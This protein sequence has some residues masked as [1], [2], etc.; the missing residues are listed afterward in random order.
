MATKSKTTEVTEVETVVAAPAKKENILTADAAR[1]QLVNIY[2]AEEKRSIYL[3]P[4][5]RP[6]LGN[7]MP[8]SINGITIFFPVDGQPHTVPATFADEI[9]AKRM[10]I[11][12][13]IYKQERMSDV[14]NNA[15]SRPG[16]LPLI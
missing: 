13:I 3:S 11:D 9:D 2:K 8:V 12:D 7:V 4:M 6:Y 16:E 10:A 5:Y 1:K 14:S 15:E